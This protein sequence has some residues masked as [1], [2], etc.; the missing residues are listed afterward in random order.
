MSL[1]NSS[2]RNRKRTKREKI[3]N[4]KNKKKSI[5]KQNKLMMNSNLAQKINK[6]RVMFLY[7]HLIKLT[8]ILKLL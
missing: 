8:K 1:N 5:V 6:Y 7:N 2:I 3:K 4:I